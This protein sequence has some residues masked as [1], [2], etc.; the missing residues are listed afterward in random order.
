MTG[1]DEL[2]LA[3]ARGRVLWDRVLGRRPVRLV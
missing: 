1:N 2:G 3:G